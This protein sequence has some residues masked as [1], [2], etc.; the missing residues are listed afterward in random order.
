MFCDQCGKELREGQAFCSSC[1]GTSI[2]QFL[3]EAGGWRRHAGIREP[4][5]SSCRPAGS[6]LDC[7]G[8]VLAHRGGG[9]CGGRALHA[10]PVW[11]RPCPPTSRGHPHRTGNGDA[12]GSG[13]P[14]VAGGR[15]CRSRVGTAATA[16]V[17]LG[18]L[19]LTTFPFGTALGIY[20]LWVLLPS[21]AKEEYYGMG[22]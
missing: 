18:C 1:G 21:E 15:E 20:T 16:L 14:A 9:D 2:L 3:R 12:T 22:G 5:H 17:G 11:P 4:P 19:S 13:L 7:L 10:R 6:P 8:R